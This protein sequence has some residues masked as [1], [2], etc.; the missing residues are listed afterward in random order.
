MWFGEE[1]RWWL[2]CFIVLVPVGFYIQRIDTRVR[3][4]KLRIDRLSLT[5]LKI[6]N[7]LS[8]IQ[9][10]LVIVGEAIGKDAADQVAAIRNRRTKVLRWIVEQGPSNADILRGLEFPD[11]DDDPVFWARD[12]LKRLGLDDNETAKE[13][14]S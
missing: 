4:M 14:G 3:Q 12:R 6:E 11:I 10:S 1:A 9:D 2:A 13:E 7:D 5:F 8:A